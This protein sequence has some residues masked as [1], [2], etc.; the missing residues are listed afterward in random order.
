VKGIPDTFEGGFDLGKEF[1]K[2]LPKH[3]VIRQT[4]SSNFKGAPQRLPEGEPRTFQY[5]NPSGS[6]MGIANISGGEFDKL[7]I[8]ESSGSVSIRKNEPI[9]VVPGKIH[10][11]AGPTGPTPRNESEIPLLPRFQIPHLLTIDGV[12]LQNWNCRF[13]LIVDGNNLHTLK[14]RPQSKVWRSVHLPSPLPILGP[15]EELR[16]TAPTNEL[17]LAARSG[18]GVV[19]GIIEAWFLLTD[20]PEVTLPHPSGTAN[21]GRNE[22]CPCGSG[23]KFKRCHGR[24]VS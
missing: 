7:T 12:Q 8:E 2:F 19:T 20:F 18:E 3:A 21:V 6:M 14:I 16:M 5:S 9:S 15:T 11:E 22:E 10:F 24:E 4:T 17:T 13:D 23:K 1:R